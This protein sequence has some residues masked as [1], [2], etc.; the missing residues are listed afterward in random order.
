MYL[1]VNLQ[2][3]PRRHSRLFSLGEADVAKL[4][5]CWNHATDSNM[6]RPWKTM[7]RLLD[8]HISL[9]VGVITYCCLRLGEL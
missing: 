2:L 9:W 1:T 5:R 8:H 4:I 3:Q 6:E 7:H